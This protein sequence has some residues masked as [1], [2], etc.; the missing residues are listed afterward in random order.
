MKNSSI[1]VFFEFQCFPS[2]NVISKTYINTH[3][4]IILIDF[5]IC[6]QTIQSQYDQ[7]QDDVELVKNENKRLIKRLESLVLENDSFKDTIVKEKREVTQLTSQLSSLTEEK[8]KLENTCEQMEKRI[9]D[10]NNEVKAELM[11]RQQKTKECE[12]LKNSLE[13][14]KRAHQTTRTRLDDMKHDRTSNNVLS[15]EVANYE[16]FI[17][18]FYFYHL[19]LYL[20]KIS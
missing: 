4:C 1:F 8:K 19:L 16:V 20:F 7:L 5:H 6:F 12:D 9:K 15:L 10:L 3:S 2:Y 11:V 17:T 13:A 14:E 18:S